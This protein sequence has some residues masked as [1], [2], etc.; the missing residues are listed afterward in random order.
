MGIATIIVVSGSILILFL[1]YTELTRRARSA[2]A[3]QSNKKRGITNKQDDGW[4]PFCVPS[5]V[6]QGSETLI[7]NTQIPALRFVCDRE[8]RGAYYTPLKLIYI[9]LARRYPEMFDGR[10]FQGW[11]EFYVRIGLFRFED[12][13][14]H[15]TC[16]GRKLLDYLVGRM[17]GDSAT[18]RS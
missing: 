13:A 18:V 9:E 16:A 17:A 1:H 3:Y 5:E 4:F 10:T 2:T 6:F 15:I 12:D 11:V 7:W 8:P 14:I